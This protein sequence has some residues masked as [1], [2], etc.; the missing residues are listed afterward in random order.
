MIP[1]A[2][3]KLPKPWITLAAAEAAKADFERLRGRK[4]RGAGVRQ[5][6]FNHAALRD[7]LRDL[8]IEYRDG[9]QNFSMRCFVAPECADHETPTLYLRHAAPKNGVWHCFRCD[10]RGYIDRLVGIKTG[11]DRHT[12]V[13]FLKNHQAYDGPD[14]TAE[15]NYKPAA[16]INLA[17]YQF[18]HTYC[19]EERKLTTETMQRYEIGFDRDLF[20]VMIPI[21]DADR[22]L[23]GIKRRSILNRSYRLV[24]ALAYHPTFFGIDKI[25]PR[26][27]VW[28]CEGEFDA[29]YVDQCLRGTSPHQ[30]AIAL[31]G[32]YL[33][34]PRLHALIALQPL[35]FVDALDNDEAGRKA[36]AA[37]REQLEQITPVMRM[38]YEDSVAKDPNDSSPRQ[39]VQ[40]AYRADYLCAQIGRSM[41]TQTA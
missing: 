11:W 33:G 35:M 31:G 15:R 24:P 22:K 4:S 18:R 30:G 2:G 6:H 38:R 19:L 41:R 26:S 14:D 21:F 17:Q 5:W 40:Q 25:E 13:A 27:I 36:S 10:A 23:V 8:G 3:S 32:L 1:Q 37:M 34:E 16:D 12:I 9:S 20:D 29:M 7:I 28:V 39:I